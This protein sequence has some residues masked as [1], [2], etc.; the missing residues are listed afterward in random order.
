MHLLDY[1]GD[2]D[3]GHPPDEIFVDRDVF[4]ECWRRLMQPAAPYNFPVRFRGQD[5]SVKHALRHLK[6]LWDGGQFVYTHCFQP[7]DVDT[8]RLMEDA[9]R[10]KSQELSEVVAAR[11]VFLS[12]AAHG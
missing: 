2:D 4:D 1:A 11:D 10:A 7:R 5:G 12:I 3:V 6:R 8:Q 9:L